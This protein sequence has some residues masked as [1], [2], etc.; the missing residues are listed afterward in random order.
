MKTDILL[1]EGRIGI[2][3]AALV[4][5]LRR[6][7]AEGPSLVVHVTESLFEP[8]VPKQHLEKFL[9][10]LE[11]VD[12]VRSA[13]ASLSEILRRYGVTPESVECRR[14]PE[15]ELS[16]YSV[17]RICKRVTVLGE[18]AVADKLTTLDDLQA[19]YGSAPRQRCEV[20]GLVSG[21]FDLIHP[22]HVR[23]MQAAKEQV[24]VLVVLTMSTSSIQQ[25]EKNRLGDRPIYSERD[26]AE[27]L[28]AL[29]PVDHLVVFDECDCLSS[30]RA[31]CPNYFIKSVDDQARPV[32]QAEAALVESLGGKT[33]YLPDHH[34]G[35]SST[36]L[37]HWV[38][39][40]EAALSQTK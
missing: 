4:R 25:Q 24:D 17:A 16:A 26:R 21:S 3:D 36:S 27:V 30:L 7:K 40:R 20:V 11:P 18:M 6:Q 33:V 19:R 22:G 8:I 29:R 9:A 28:S 32:V 15:A 34:S 5:W 37:I 2:V 23:L 31:F 1:A 39:Q 35:Y 12:E 10:A 14:V 13:D 38:Q